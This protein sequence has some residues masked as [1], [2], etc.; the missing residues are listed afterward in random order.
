MTL[1][2]KSIFICGIL[3]LQS[4]SAQI[5]CKDIFSSSKSE[6]SVQSSDPIVNLTMD[7]TQD[8][9]DEIHWSSLVGK[10]VQITYKVADEESFIA[11]SM[12]QMF[13]EASLKGKIGLQ[14]LKT[15]DLFDSFEMPNS[16]KKEF[17]E[18]GLEASKKS[19]EVAIVGYRPP[20]GAWMFSSVISG[21]EFSQITFEEIEEA[22]F[23]LG[24]QL[25]GN[26]P[27]IKLQDVEIAVLHT[28]PELSPFN[29]ADKNA[30]NTLKSLAHFRRVFGVAVSGNTPI[31]KSI[32][33]IYVN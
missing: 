14:V 1:L 10:K 17:Y 30:A 13:G 11:R 29:L 4:A 3:F 8:D 33:F 6:V 21:R 9:H 16:L 24:K 20:G 32:G 31:E 22:S 15:E 12:K 18:K 19:M 28:H 26:N 5:E 27:G 2:S 23:Q 7:I 25:I